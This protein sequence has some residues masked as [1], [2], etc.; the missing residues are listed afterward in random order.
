MNL[1]LLE[2]SGNQRYIFA[3][4]K[5][6]ENVGAS[7]LTYRVGTKT[8]LETVEEATK[9]QHEKDPAKQSVKLWANDLSGEQV[10]ANLLDPSLNPKLEDHKSDIEVIV[11]TSGKAILLVR[12]KQVGKDL[13]KHVTQTALRDMPGLTL[14]GAISSEVEDSLSNIHE[15]IVEVHHI[16]ESIRHQIPGNEQRFLRLPFFAQ[17]ATSGLP[18]QKEE[19][20]EPQKKVYSQVSCVKA[21]NKKAGR[22]RVQRIL[23]GVRLIEPEKI[24][25]CAWTAVIH[26]DGNDLGKIFLNFDKY[27]GFDQHK[28]GRK[29]LNAYREFSLALDVCT[30]KATRTA[31]EHLRDFEA[32]KEA[33]KQNKGVEDL[34]EEELKKLELPVVPIVLGGDDLTVLCDGEYALRFTKD[35]LMEFESQTEQ[36]H[37]LVGDIVKQ[38][39]SKASTSSKGYLGIC[40]GIAIVKPHFPFHQ[41]YE[42]AESLLR[43]AKNV[44]QK[45]TTAPSSAMDFHILYD[46]AYSDLDLIR[47]KL[48]VDGEKTHLYAK[49]Y[50]VTDVE[51]LASEARNDWLTPRKFGELEKRVEIMRASDKG[52]ASKRALPNSQLHGLREALFLG[53]READARMSL[54]KQRYEDKSFDKL[55]C[56]SQTNDEKSDPIK[57]LFFDEKGNDNQRATHF[58]DA[59]DVVGFWKGFPEPKSKSDSA[60]Q[61]DNGGK[62]N[63]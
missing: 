10:R 32:Q 41:A 53:W 59:L 48:R 45:I 35:F 29:Y 51:K 47:E 43:S 24:E 60:N 9:E 7:E 49:P 61:P 1:V 20:Y 33:R 39:A 16:L 63:E 31:L 13:I 22:N 54:I 44:K 36:S 34:T 30:E 4:N 52:D 26:A 55:L 19:N 14:H 2:T 11:A 25:K 12:T 27:S 40:A 46:S 5:L 17:C 42:L 28:D 3:T 62:E 50:V 38:I 57:S 56:E 21:D 23:S 6:R 18:A 15:A 58:L 8:V 37:E